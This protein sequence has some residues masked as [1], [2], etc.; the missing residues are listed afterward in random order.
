VKLGL[1]K[2]VESLRKAGESR[3]FSSVKTDGVNGMGNW[4]SKAFSRHVL[5]LIGK[6]EKGKFGFHSLRTSFIQGLQT[7]GVADIEINE[8][9]LDLFLVRDLCKLYG[10][11][12]LDKVLAEVDRRVKKGVSEVPVRI[13]RK[14]R[15]Q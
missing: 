4:L 3:L 10:A 12:S 13:V 8:R 11:P 14:D 2:R 7:L 15:K 5:A 9:G 1:L 6:P